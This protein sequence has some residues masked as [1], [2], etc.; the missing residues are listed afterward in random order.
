VR[1][2]SKNRQRTVHERSGRAIGDLVLVQAAERPGAVRIALVKSGAIAARLVLGPRGGGRTRLRALVE[3]IYFQGAP[4]SRSAASSRGAARE[5]S[6]ALLLSWLR[7]QPPGVPALDPTD[8]PGPDE[9]CAR[10]HRYA[11]AL[12]RGETG[13]TFR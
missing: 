12:L 1:A 8:D 6:R 2:P 4:R 3:E 11:A 5:A 9:A 10:I 7:R 13:V